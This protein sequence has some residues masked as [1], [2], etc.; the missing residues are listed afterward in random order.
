[1]AA[2][3]PQAVESLLENNYSDIE[4][5]I[6]DDGSTDETSRYLREVAVNA[7]FKIPIKCI[8][9]GHAGKAAA[10]N[11]G[12]K[13]AA[14]D[15]ITFLDADDTLPADSLSLR[16][17][18]LAN[19]YSGI[20]LGEFEIFNEKEITGKRSLPTE[21]ISNLIRGLLYGLKV[22]FHLN[23]MLIKRS[24]IETAGTFDESL[25][26]C[27]EKDYALRLLLMNP[28]I[29][30]IHKPVYSYRKYRALKHRVK[31]RLLTCKYKMRMLVKHTTGLQMVA[32]VV[33]NTIIE[34]GKF[35][36]EIFGSYRK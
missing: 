24:L 10:L 32:A 12:L 36:Y 14:G 1:M 7:D 21:K 8:T 19:S 20:T 34:V 28:D 4:I 15:Y 31:I 13:Q 33:W 3:L 18:R 5:I 2:Y 26:R 9:I 30:F 16:V 25:Y 29:A 27:Q 6:V 23:S 11:A 35:G 22:P 17:R